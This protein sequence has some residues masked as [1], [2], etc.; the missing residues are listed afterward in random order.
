[1]SE[2]PG[3][4]LIRGTP[5]AGPFEKLDPSQYSGILC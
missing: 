2:P 4:A 5:E 3:A 1:M